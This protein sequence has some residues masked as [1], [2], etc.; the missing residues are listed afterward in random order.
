M[1]V[2]TYPYQILTPVGNRTDLKLTVPLYAPSPADSPPPPTTTTTTRGHDAV[3]SSTLPLTHLGVWGD[4]GT[5]APLGFKVFDK[6]LA[7]HQVGL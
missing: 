1:C 5:V 2:Q 6:I 7:D 3:S 4:M